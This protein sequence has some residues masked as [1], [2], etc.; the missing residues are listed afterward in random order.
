L[1]ERE[2]F[3]KVSIEYA[4]SG[5]SLAFDLLPAKRTLLD[6]IALRSRLERPH[7]TREN[8]MRAGRFARRQRLSGQSLQSLSS[9][10]DH[11]QLR[12]TAIFKT[13]HRKN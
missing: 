13:A 5:I 3:K 10:K 2:D 8:I 7:A 4:L 1:I 12:Q 11:G 9:R 6:A